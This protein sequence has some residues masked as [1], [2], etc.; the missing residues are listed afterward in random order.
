MTIADRATIV[1]TIPA[2]AFARR[3]L[4]WDQPRLSRVATTG[5][6]VPCLV[7]RGSSP[8]V[9]TGLEPLYVSA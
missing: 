9:T 5:W 6:D 7:G 1:D 8:V 4:E 3:P 2:T